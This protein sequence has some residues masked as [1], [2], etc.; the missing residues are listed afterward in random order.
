M[1]QPTVEVRFKPLLTW[2]QPYAEQERRC[3]HYQW[4]RYAFC[5]A[6]HVREPFH[7]EDCMCRDL[8]P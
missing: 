8:Q 7:I 5:A 6:M 2:A 3:I 4:M 1:K